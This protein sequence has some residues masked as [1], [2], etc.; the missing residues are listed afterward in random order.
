MLPLQGG[1]LKIHLIMVPLYLN[2][3]TSFSLRFLSNYMVFPL[4]IAVT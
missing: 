4:I 1:R 3:I 2:C